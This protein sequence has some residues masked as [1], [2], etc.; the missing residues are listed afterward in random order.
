[1]MGRAFTAGTWLMMLVATSCAASSS[2]RAVSPATVAA[3][4]STTTV[5]AANPTWVPIDL[6]FAHQNFYPQFVRD[7]AG[8]FWVLGDVM[9]TPHPATASEIDQPQEWRSLDGVSWSA[10][11][12]PSVGFGPLSTDSTTNVAHDGDAIVIIGSTAG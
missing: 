11:V 8:E 5:S 1:M 10:V 6:P 9:R 7:D 4:D 12:L 3:A 2:H